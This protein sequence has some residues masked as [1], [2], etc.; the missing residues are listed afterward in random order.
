MTFDLS[1]AIKENMDLIVKLI[2]MRIFKDDQKFDFKFKNLIFNK[3]FTCFYS[4]KS[5]RIIIQM[6]FLMKDFDFIFESESLSG[7][8]Y[9]KKNSIHQD[10]LCNNK[11]RNK[12]NKDSSLNLNNKEISLELL[13]FILEQ[14][15][16]NKFFYIKN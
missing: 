12:R 7:I 4:F 15:I 1:L 8:F 11:Y 10:I 13:I 16:F 9:S 5:S 3:L 6:I 2:K 14:Q